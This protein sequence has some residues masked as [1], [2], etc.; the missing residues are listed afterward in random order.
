MRCCSELKLEAFVRQ[1]V[2]AMLGGPTYES[3]AEARFVKSAGRP[4]YNDIIRP[5]I[6]VAGSCCQLVLG[7]AQ[8]PG[9]GPG[10]GPGL[11]LVCGDT[12]L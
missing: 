1:G 11:G 3:P 10:A 9:A 8:R 4:A 12:P 5:C 7:E 2:Y 6:S